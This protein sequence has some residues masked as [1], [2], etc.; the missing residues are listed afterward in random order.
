M[1]SLKIASF[2][3][4]LLIAALVVSGC[5]PSVSGGISANQWE[6]VVKGQD[7]SV[8]LSRLGEPVSKEPRAD[9]GERWFYTLNGEK[10]AVS[11]SRVGTVTRKDEAYMFRPLG[12]KK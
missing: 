8:V 5:S 3:T 12:M 9:D 2:Q 7:R 11:F 10:V 4:V 6:K 1:K